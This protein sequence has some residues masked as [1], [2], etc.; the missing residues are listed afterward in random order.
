MT[1]TKYDLHCH[2][3][4]SDG[5]FSPS[6]VV[7]KAHDVAIDVLALTDHDTTAG[8]AEARATAESL[9]MQLINGIEL[10][11][12]HTLTGGY[13]KN[14]STTK[15]IHVVG[16]DFADIELMNKRLQQV[17]ESRAN[18]GRAIVSKLT[19]LLKIDDNE[20]W[21]AVLKKA[22]RNAQAVCRPH[23][24]KTLCEMGIVQSIPQAFNKYLGDNQPAY[25]KI[26]TLSMAEGIKLIQEC[27]GKAVLA[28]P[29]KYNLSATRIRKLI[30][31]FAQ[32]GGDA[33]EVPTDKE[34][35]S[36]RR[37]VDR[38]IADN[39]LA[40]SVGSDFHGANIPYIKLGTVPK[41]TSEQVGIWEQFSVAS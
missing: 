24:A 1:Y 27:G 37:M 15:I 31:E 22:N 23:I 18:R 38:V 10:S 34:P 2:S 7:K 26:D 25:V 16:L 4:C 17:Q 12:E 21:Q 14:K 20:F 39:K 9:N 36:K 8:L 11:C 28:H 40:V 19:H 32:L 5:T 35:L 30:A 33:S 29:S 41:L 3:T 13:G 6:E